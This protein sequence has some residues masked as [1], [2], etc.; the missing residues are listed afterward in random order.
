MT[1]KKRAAIAATLAALALASFAVP[2]AVPAAGEAAKAAPPPVVLDP[3]IDACAECK[4]SVKDSGYA[5]QVIAKDGRVY[6]FDD[7]GCLLA[8]LKANPSVEAAA[9][10]VQDSG[11]K[12]WLGLEAAWYVVAKEVETPMGYGIHAFASKGAAEAFAAAR[13]AGTKVVRLPELDVGAEANLK[14]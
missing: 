13:K 14:M 11:T 8:Y 1:T 6:K 2:A 10:Y 5:A 9:R 4:M 12:T 3:A 7:L